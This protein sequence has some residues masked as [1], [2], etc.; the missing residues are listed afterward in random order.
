MFCAYDI[1]GNERQLTQDY[2]SGF[3]NMKT[4]RHNRFKRLPYEKGLIS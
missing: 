2:G 3:A 4:A 1:Y